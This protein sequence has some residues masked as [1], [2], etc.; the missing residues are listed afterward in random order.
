MRTHHWPLFD[1][2]VRTPRLE[3]RYA[4][5]ELTLA[6]AELGAR[7]VHAPE[8]MPFNVPWTDAPLG[9]QERNSLQHYW[10]TRATWT[11][12]SWRCPMV[13]L[14]DGEVVGA[15]G[16]QADRFSLAREFST[17]SWLGRD[18]QGKGIGKDMRAA[19]LHLGFAGLGAAR[20][21][22]AAFHDNLPSLGVTKS[23]GYEANGEAY[24][25]RRDTVD[26]QLRFVL[27]RENWE[28][29][30]RD[31]IE[32]EGLEPCLALFGATTS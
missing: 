21:H 16:I 2:V 1:L 9:E 13:V 24:E 28:A 32:I 10:L 20:A 27:T 15:Q 6:A 22:T 3:L 25:T 29:Q 4:D 17:G 12:D 31:D 26:R 23:I 11:R 5:D 19:I 14:V 30:R 7:G 8:M 18:H